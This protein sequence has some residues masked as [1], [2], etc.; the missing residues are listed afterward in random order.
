[1]KKEIIAIVTFLFLLE[2]VLAQEPLINI[3]NTGFG[4]TPNEL[5]FTIHN[6]GKV[7]ITNPTIYVDGNESETIS[8]A[9]LPNG[10]YETILY[11]EPGEHLI[12]VK[13]PEGAYDS[14]KVT[15][16]AIKEK[17]YISPE[18]PKP[19]LDENIILI[20]LATLIIIIVIIAWLLTRRPKLKV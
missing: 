18:E 3:E 16:A 2:L 15:V 17:P 20:G 11:L 12:E 5:F 13:T 9:L 7:K 8:S 14:V 10:G 1:M 6:I 19:F 4:K